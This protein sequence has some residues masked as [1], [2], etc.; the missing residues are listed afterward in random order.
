MRIT[1]R[2]WFGLLVAGAALLLGAATVATRAPRATSAGATPGSLVTGT[3]PAQAKPAVPPP[4]ALTPAVPLGYEPPVNLTP[5]G[6]AT[7]VAYPTANPGD[8]ALLANGNGRTPTA[9]ASPPTATA[10]P[11]AH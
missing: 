4:V 11:Q 3:V 7:A 6:R 9:T 10:S 8:A 2:Y 5:V 1:R